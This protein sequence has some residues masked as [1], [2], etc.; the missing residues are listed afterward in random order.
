M[1]WLCIDSNATDTFKAQKGS[2]DSIEIVHVSG[3]TLI[4]GK[5]E[6]TFSAQKNKN[7]LIQQFFSSVSVFDVRSWQYHDVMQVYGSC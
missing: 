3:S 5:Y 7:N 1:F 2:K 4:L 6:N